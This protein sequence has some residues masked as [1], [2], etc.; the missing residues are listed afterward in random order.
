LVTAVHHLVLNFLFPYAVFPE[1]SFVRVILHAILVIFESATL[2]LLTKHIC[3]AMAESEN[4]L[5]KTKEYEEKEKEKQ[6]LL[7]KTKAFDEA[8]EKEKEIQEEISIILNQLLELDLTKRIPIHNKKGFVLSL[9][10][11]V[12]N[13]MDALHTTVTEISKVMDSAAQG[14]LSKRIEEDCPGSFS[15]LKENINATLDKIKN[16]M[17]SA[18]EITNSI[19]VDTDEMNSKN[20]EVSNSITKQLSNLKN[21]VQSLNIISKDLSDTSTDAQQAQKLASENQEIAHDANVMSQES[22]KGLK[23]ISS[24]SENIASIISVIDSIAFQTNLLGLN[25]SVEAARAGE[26]G[27]GFAVVAEEVKKLADKSSAASK[28]IKILVEES[29]HDVYHGV[30]LVENTSVAFE[31]IV[32]VTD[33]VS[34]VLEKIASKSSSQVDSVNKAN[35]FIREIEEINENNV[36]MIERNKE[37]SSNFKNQIKQ[38]N[39]LISWFSNKK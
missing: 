16:I 7:L 6:A 35:T 34:T 9:T 29:K 25:A 4:A 21:F 28:E 2:I 31:K 12:N 20:F 14:D 36:L 3:D 39:S 13:L 8:N 23:N 32:V 30:D 26:N 1:A 10:I 38:L 15:N 5:I 19:S 18:A 33:Q 24:S 22:I 11:G 17:D 37:I 27:K